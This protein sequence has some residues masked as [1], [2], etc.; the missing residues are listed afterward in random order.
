VLPDNGD[1]FAHKLAD[2]VKGNV[3]SWFVGIV[4]GDELPSRA[5]VSAGGIAGGFTRVHSNH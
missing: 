1:R 3:L 4:L 2:H 5:D